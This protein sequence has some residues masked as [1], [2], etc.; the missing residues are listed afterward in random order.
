[1]EEKNY[2]MVKNLEQ[3]VKK[4]IDEQAKLWDEMV[5]RRII[6]PAT[7]EAPKLS[8]LDRIGLWAQRGIRKTDRVSQ[9]RD[10]SDLLFQVRCKFL[11]LLRSTSTYYIFLPEE[12][13][14]RET[15]R[16]PSK[17]SS[18]GIVEV[19]RQGQLAIQS[20]WSLSQSGDELNFEVTCPLAVFRQLVDLAWRNYP[21][22]LI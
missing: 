21:Q 20:Q 10:L 16:S 3:F 8:L 6:L 15:H 5:K 1:M 12:I 9:H 2:E 18:V 17:E 4:Q 11:T 13:E 22:D 19:Y 7:V 14:I